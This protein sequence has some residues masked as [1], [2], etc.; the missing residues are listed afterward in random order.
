MIRILGKKSNF[1]FYF[2]HLDVDDEKHCE[3]LL[4]NSNKIQPSKQDNQQLDNQIIVTTTTKS[5]ADLT[6]MDADSSTGKICL[7][8]K[9]RQT[10][11][12]MKF[13]FLF[14][15]KKSK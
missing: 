13:F 4:K 6:T 7:I 15:H 12:Q 9:K 5:T 14:F 10:K 1:F 2:Y 8:Q 11:F 3:L